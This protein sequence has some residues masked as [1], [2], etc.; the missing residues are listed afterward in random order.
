M[1]MKPTIF[2]IFL[3]PSPF[4]LSLF[5]WAAQVLLLDMGA[6]ISSLILFCNIKHKDSGK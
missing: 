4:I 1:K 6:T 5:A 3:L 2:E